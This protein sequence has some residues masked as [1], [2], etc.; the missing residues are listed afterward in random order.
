MTINIPKA[1]PFAKKI[2]KALRAFDGGL[3]DKFSPL[4]LDDKEL[5]DIQ[6]FNFD[7]KGSLTKRKGYLA[8]Y[9]S[10]FDPSPVR[11]ATNYRKAD[12]TSRLVLAA[13]DKLYSDQPQFVRLYT[14]E[15][16]W[17]TVGVEMNGVNASSTPGDIVLTPMGMLGAM[18][19]GAYSALLGGASTSTRSG[20][21]QSEPINYS[22]VTNK[23]SGIV[24]ITQ[25]VPASTTIVVETR[26]SADG[27]TGWSAYA[28]LGVGNTI[29]S[30]ANNYIQV[31]V[32]MTSTVSAS[33]SVQSLQ[34]TFDTTA[35][36]SVLASGLSTL[37]RYIFAVQ[38]DNLYITNG[39]NVMSKWDG[40]T[41]TATSPG[42][43]PTAKYAFV[44]KNLMFL[45]GNSTNP[46][47]LYFSALSDP[48][49]WPAL[50]FIDVGKGDGD[51]ITGLAFLLDRL[52]VTKQNSVWILEGDS[53]STF[54]LRR[55]TD[56]AGCVDMHS[57]VTVNNTLGMLGRDGYYFFDGVRM[58]LAS[59]KI[60]TTFDAL[61]K[62][63][64]ALV[65]S[66]H[67]P[68]IR[69]VFISVP[70]GSMT[71]NDTVLVFD[72][73]RAAWTKYKGINAASWVTWRQFNVDHLLFGSAT[74]GQ[75]YDAETGYSDDGAAIACYAVTKA[76]DLG[77]TELSKY[78]LT[79]EV[80]AKETTGTGD[81]TVA[82]SFFTDLMTTETAASSAAVS[83]A[84]VN[85]KR[86]FP[87]ITSAST[88]RDIAVKIAESS[89]NRSITIFGVVLEA[90][91]RI[92][93]RGTY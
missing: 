19:L 72:T 64:L 83:G 17:E 23:T 70:S 44:H 8:H 71:S 65:A 61:N 90:Q 82:V 10:T 32:T 68:S 49:S 50:N 5:S 41:Y 45:A 81:A 30:A 89:T 35:T 1:T 7:Q 22:A 4:L 40:T 15:A 31:R 84:S 33:P 11:C 27:A 74:V 39:V 75:M 16:D 58:Q 67:F 93:V 79:S 38:N 24:A 56:L 43:P 14:L 78:I 36:V 48:E 6:N 69:K 25:T 51:T 42:S 80:T 3:N 76:E 52:I 88:V 60:S 46:S 87:A 63:Q 20:T 2:I 9:A 21:W 37:A 12:G 54:I 92:G 66:E 57:I 77:G 28:A 73:L 29:V 62:S 55:A 91:P 85:V 18:L 59:E 47:R 34:V 53:S 86:V 26:T 13:S